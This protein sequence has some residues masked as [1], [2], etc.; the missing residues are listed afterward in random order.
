MASNYI[1]VS[2]GALKSDASELKNQAETAK[3]KLAE[4]KHGI[5]VLDRMWDG[6][7]NVAFTKQFNIDYELFI[8]ICANVSKFASDLE[9]AAKEYDRC[10][11]SVMD[12]VK[13]IRV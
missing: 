4:M 1:K 8:D 6:P 5:E 3:S 10:E 13:A 9:R 7:A 11:D 12:V 2:T